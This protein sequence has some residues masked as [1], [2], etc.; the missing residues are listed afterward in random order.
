MLPVGVEE[1]DRKVTW[2]EDADNVSAAPPTVFT[3]VSDALL[4]PTLNTEQNNLLQKLENA[5]VL[6]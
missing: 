6:T 5:S 1:E 3:Q 4:R 2:M